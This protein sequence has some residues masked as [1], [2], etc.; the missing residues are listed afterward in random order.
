MAAVLDLLE[1]QP[2]LGKANAA[3][4]RNDGYQKSLRED[5]LVK[6]VEVE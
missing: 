1:T 3:F 4:E 5:K 2:H 6:D